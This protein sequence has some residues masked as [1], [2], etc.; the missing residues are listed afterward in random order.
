[1]SKLSRLFEQCWFLRGNSE[2]AYG[3]LC[4]SIDCHWALRNLK[5]YP[6]VAQLSFEKKPTIGQSKNPRTV[7]LEEKDSCRN[8]R[9]ENSG[10]V[11]KIWVSFTLFSIAK[12]NKPGP[13]SRCP[14]SNPDP[15]NTIG[16]FP[17][18]ELHFLLLCCRGFLLFFFFWGGG[19]GFLSTVLSLSPPQKNTFYYKVQVFIRYPFS[20][21]DLKL[22][23]RN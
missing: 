20:Y 14:V 12:R 1:M 9:Q 4:K 2:S 11:D 6:R 15:N 16:L 19:G 21:F 13:W 18:W 10:E 8:M 5:V 23:R 3:A 7:S 17:V 22:A